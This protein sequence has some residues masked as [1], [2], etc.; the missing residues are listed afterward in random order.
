MVEE[1]VQE[2]PAAR[3]SP[4]K[5]VGKWALGLL[6]ALAL[7]IGGGLVVLNTPLG[8]RWLASQIARTTLPNGLNIQIGRIEGNLYGAAVLHDVRLSDPQ[9]VF[10]TIPRAEVDWNPG[11]WL[12]NRLEIDSF[13]ARRATLERIPEFI[14]SEEEGPILPGFDISIDSFEIDNLML[15]PGIA[16]ERAQRVD[17]AGEAQVEDRRLLVDAR[18]RLG[19]SD[20][21]ALLVDAEPDGD[22]FDLSL[23]LDAAADGPVAA[24]AGLD[25]DYTARIRGD[26]SWS[27]WN[28]SLLVR[29]ADARVAALRVT[30]RGGQF[31]L[32][33]K[34]DPSNF[35]TGLPLDALGRDVAVRSSITIDDRIFDGRAQV[36]GQGLALDAIGAVNLAENRVDDLQVDAVL[37]DP[38]LFGP[39]LTL[40]NARA[41]ATID[42]AFSDLTIVHNLAVSEIDAGGTVLA[43]LRQQ[44]TARYDGTRW[45]LPINLDLG[46]VTSGNALVDPRLVDGT[47]RG[48]LV[49]AGSRLLA[50]DLRLS[51]PSTSANLA[52]RGDL[53]SGSYQIRGPLRA[54]GLALD[55][56]GTVGGTAVIDL[57][58]ASGAPWRV[59]ADLDAR[60]APVT[61]DTLA[62]LAGTPIRVR[63]GLAIGGDRPLVFDDVR[64]DASKLAMRLDGSVRDGTTSIAGNGRHTEYGAFTVVASLDDAG[65]TAELVF[66]APVTGLTDVRVAIAPTEEGFAIDTTGQS[67]IGP[68]DGRLGLFAPASGPTRIDIESLRF[69]DTDVTGGL[70]LVDGGAQGQLAFAGGGLDG[71]IDLAP[72]AGGQGLAIDLTARNASFGGETPV[73]IARAR[74]D[75]QGVI[76]DGGT[77]FTGTAR[78]AG[79]SFGTVFIGRFAAQGELEDGV[80]RVDASIS[81]RRNSRF[82]LDLNARF[83]SERIAVAARGEFAGRD[84]TMP[85]RAVLTREGESWRLA[86]TQVK[87]GDGGLI[88]A[89]RVGGGDL[90]LDLKLARMPLALVDIA[91]ADT[92][93]GGTISGTVD[94]RQSA[95]GL[96]ISEAKVKIDGLTRSG[97]I[98][99]S[100]PVDVSLVA[101]LGGDDLEVRGLLRNEEIQRGR[102][103]ARISGLPASGELLE[104]LRAGRLLAQ[105]RYRGA[106]ESLWR[107]A[108]ID[109]FDLT[110]PVAVAADATG[111]LADP[112]VRGSVSSDALRVQSSLSGTDIRS[113][114]MRG[115]FAGSRLQI[116]RFAGETPNGGSVSGSGIVDLRT[117]GE[118]VE[119]RILEIRGP[120]IDLR[121]SARNARL[122]NAAGLSATITGPLRIVSNGLGGTIAGRVRVDQASWGLG[123]AA[124][125]LRLPQIATREI[126]APANR[127]PQAAPGRPWRYLIDATAS[128]RIDVDGMGL[129]SEWGADIILR[130]TTD[131][132]RIGGRAEVVRGDYTFAGTRFE[133]TRGRI[134]FDENQP[135]DPRLDIRAETD[136]DGLTVEVTVRGSA[137][138]PEIAF[139]SN[140]ALPEEEILARL[141]FGGSVTSLSATDALQLGAA[142]ASL[143]GGGGMDPINQLRSAIG[144]DRLRIVSAD[145]ALGRGTGVALG[146][147][148]GRRFYAEIIT[149]GRGYSA[150]ELE[151]RVSS[152]LSLLAAVSTV[153]RES[154]VA[155][156]S[157]DY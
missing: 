124:D 24:L 65:P 83:Q 137:T 108:A 106:A 68:F 122:L 128:S 123:T 36:Q 7:L 74:V 14:P 119:G 136:R 41:E 126:N 98:L 93:L 11:A 116:T 37:R 105:L 138:Q 12:Y 100:R 69:T 112:T 79:L 157:R 70:T 144:L 51:F 22:R 81:G 152:W 4:L 73:R 94:Y 57:T 97:L 99:T 154:V 153:G 85:R 71:T 127:Q 48:T 150:T 26:G 45:T 6:A 88:A 23:D 39:D 46:R 104:R 28:G 90:A 132:P 156:I 1:S 80:G 91:R 33:G 148:F 89:G 140:P 31:G 101:R 49:L 9:G 149:D 8:E 15:A 21:V 130:G 38:N 42:G 19:E 87:Y 129:E 131:D 47:V 121:A 77:N 59:T 155:E 114:A 5:R 102:V 20:R 43:G 113:V 109:A 60:V 35:L 67:P 10:M 78:G 25:Q 27:R 32:L 30:N 96:P 53:D 92:G 54:S 118:P 143:R 3:R 86:P 56:V 134:D 151:F 110:G 133:L 141:L 95:N 135:I 117:L 111:T 18:G 75:A 16:G 52:L 115:R 62:N 142:V 76:G 146:K 125:D 66:A 44:G 82:E 34:V 2:T 17:L 40:R 147:N 63:G 103:Q 72:R 120:I 58:L 64:V 55:N 84:I 13:A 61:N 145:P 50:D 139:S 107:L 29:S